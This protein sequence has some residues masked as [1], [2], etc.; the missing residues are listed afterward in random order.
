MSD[1]AQFIVVHAFMAVLLIAAAVPLFR[2]S[3]R[4]NGIVK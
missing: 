4:K 1:F 2:E 3:G